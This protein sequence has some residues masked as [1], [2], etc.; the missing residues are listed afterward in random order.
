MIK[1]RKAA[2]TMS[3]VAGLMVEDNE[4]VREYGV[5]FL[6]DASSEWG[7]PLLSRARQFHPAGLGIRPPLAGPFLERPSRSSL[8]TITTSPGSS[9]RSMRWSSG[10]S[11]RAPLAFS[12]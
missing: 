11:D 6:S 4:L 10:R 9:E 8:V 3:S 1:S 5:E 2:R 12:A 7:T